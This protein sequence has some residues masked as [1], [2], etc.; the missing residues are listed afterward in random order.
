MPEKMLW[1]RELPVI[2]CSL[3][4]EDLPER[5]RRWR[6]LLEGSL[7]ERTEI[8]GGVRLGL[9]A[10]DGVEQELRALAALERQ[11]CAFASFEVSA[12]EARVTLDV[13]SSADGVAAVRELFL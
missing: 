9:R 10:G 13:T 3:T 5:R 2:A 12:T 11:C 1:M 8:P 7:L 4:A 6:A